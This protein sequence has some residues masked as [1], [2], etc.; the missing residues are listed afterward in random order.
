VRSTGCVDDLNDKLLSDKS[1]G[2]YS[3]HKYYPE[4]KNGWLLAVTERRTRQE[5]DRFVERA[6]SYCG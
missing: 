2:G 1:I 5:I 4:L 3:L 6:V